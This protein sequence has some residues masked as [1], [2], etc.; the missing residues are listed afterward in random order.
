MW[1][2]GG[3]HSRTRESVG[4]LR[5]EKL[6]AAVPVNHRLLARG[7]MRLEELAS[8][9]LIV[10]PKAPRPS[11]ADQVLA[12]YRER[13]LKPPVLYEVR[14]LQTA[15]GLVAAES[16]VCVCRP[17]SNG[18]GATTL[19]IARWMNGCGFADHHEHAQGGSFAG[20]RAH[21]EADPGDV[22]EGGN[23]FGA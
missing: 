4:F 6:F 1:G 19:S 23:T 7:P 13:G 14:E 3:F 12:L 18:C 15:L 8:E 5:N 11:Y 21:A 17:L 10:Y 9:P 16:G 2:S 20:D 22:Q